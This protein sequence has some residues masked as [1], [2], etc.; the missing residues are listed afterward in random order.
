MDNYKNNIF[1]KYPKIKL[2]YNDLT[3][4]LVT[5]VQPIISFNKIPGKL[6]TTIIVDPDAPSPVNPINK[7]HLHYLQINN[8]EVINE[9]QG[10]NPPIGSGIHRY[11]TCVFEQDYR[12]EKISEFARSKF[13]LNKFVH[14]N[15]LNLIGCF[16]FRVRG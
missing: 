13:D 10:P 14:N 5:S 16:K 9:Y 11:Y 3:N 8:N 7:Y 6:Y 12:L 1:L 15:K 4:K 2:D